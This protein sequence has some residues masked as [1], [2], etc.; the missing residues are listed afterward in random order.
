MKNL[1]IS[2][3]FALL[4]ISG[5]V[6][7]HEAPIRVVVLGEDSDRDSVNRSSEIYK[8]VVAE[9]QQSMIRENITVID[10][11]M[12]AVKLGFSY[13]TDRTKQELIQ[14]L[15]IANETTDAT[16]RSRLGVIFAIFPNIQEMSMTRKL[17]VRVR[18]QIYDLKSLRALSSFEESAPEKV[19]IS[20]SK[21]IYVP[22]Y[23]EEDNA[24][25][26][27]DSWYKKSLWLYLLYPFSLIFSFI[28]N[29]RRKKFLNNEYESFESDIPII[30]V[31]NLTI[32]GTGK[33]PLVKHIA[34]ELIKRGY[35]PGIVSRGYGGKFKETLQVTEDTP[36]KNTGDEA[37]ILAKLNIPFYIDKNR[38]RAVKTIIKNHNCD[39]II[40]DDGLQHY[41]MGRDIEIAVIDGKRRFGN[42]LTFPAGP[43]RESKKRLQSVDFIVNNSGPTEENEYLMSIS[44]SKF[45]HL[46]SGKS[47]SVEKWPMHKQIHAVAG[48]G[49][50][51]RFFDLLE[52]LGFDINRHPF[53]DHHNFL[54]SDIYY[55]DHLPIVMTEKDAS[56][57]KD[58]DNNKIWYLTIDADVNNKFIENI[59]KR[60]KSILNNE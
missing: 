43:L 31:G 26:V 30:V 8:R 45:V 6:N 50:P 58:F 27:V 29:R 40:S 16:V 5:A 57:C 33:T 55:L 22:E 44:P 39:V 21:Q 14:T 17:T 12:I 4:P 52:K 1:I 38:V 24:S 7:A 35:K 46:K 36:V 19:E 42:S 28:T 18:G 3:L 15:S 10:E 37:Q 32:G 25:F 49:N 2:A 11:D 54:S 56:K 51:G 13:N 47:Y 20:E 48:L 9:L 53:P 23:D 60:L 59:D 41:A 34:L